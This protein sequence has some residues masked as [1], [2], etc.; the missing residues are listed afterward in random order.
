MK[1]KIQSLGWIVRRAIDPIKLGL[2]YKNKIGL[3]ELRRRDNDK[4]KNIMLWGGMLN[5]LETMSGGK[6]QQ[7]NKKIT[8]F[9]IIPVFRCNNISNT[10]KYLNDHGVERI[11]SDYNYKGTLF[12]LDPE[13]FAFGLRQSI[14]KPTL[15]PDIKAKS[16]WPNK[17]LNLPG[18]SP[19][20]NSIQDIGWLILHVK[21]P[22]KIIKFYSQ[23]VGLTVLDN[24]EA[25][26]GSL[27]LGCTTT[28]EVRHGGVEKTIP[29]DRVER[30]DVWILRG[31]GF[32]DFQRKMK[33]NGVRLINELTLGAGKLNYYTDTEGH[34]FGFQERKAFEK[35]DILT[36]R[37][38]DRVAKTE[39]DKI[40]KVSDR[41]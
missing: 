27:Y 7:K 18:V 36:H 41:S 24:N 29:K 33:I 23:I 11:D 22:Q 34:V 40:N 32:A 21:N 1:Y 10:T 26:V 2:F 25:S 39:W 5:V 35:D 4:V 9:E 15:I 14:A 6:V 13:G 20:A 8:D 19:L 3:P 28:L 16:I 31:Y 30:P 17:L 38:E 37:I 12:F